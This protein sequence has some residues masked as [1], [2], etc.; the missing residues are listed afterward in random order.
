[1][2]GGA[3]ELEGGGYRVVWGEDAGAER[4]EFE[5]LLDDDPTVQLD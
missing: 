5:G 4:S 3:R 2:E 1:M